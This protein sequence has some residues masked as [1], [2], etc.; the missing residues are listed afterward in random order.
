MITLLRIVNHNILEMFLQNGI[1][2]L[3]DA[4]KLFSDILTNSGSSG[5]EL[6]FQSI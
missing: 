1:L 3:T 6:E 2:S 4:E 5:F